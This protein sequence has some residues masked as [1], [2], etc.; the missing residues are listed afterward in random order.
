MPWGRAS[1]ATVRPALK[2]TSKSCPRYPDH[3]LRQGRSSTGWVAM[4][5]A[6]PRAAFFNLWTGFRMGD[7]QCSSTPKKS[8]MTWRYTSFL[9]SGSQSRRNSCG[10]I[11]LW[12]RNS[13][14]AVWRLISESVPRN[15]QR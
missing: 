3:P 9:K 10:A 11:H 13:G 4:K 8:S 1:K 2:S 7:R 14:W 6:T 15:R 12:L 5:V